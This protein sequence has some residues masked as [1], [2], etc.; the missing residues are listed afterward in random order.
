MCNLMLIIILMLGLMVV[1]VLVGGTL[2]G[3]W[4]PGN[5]KEIGVLGQIEV[6]KEFFFSPMV[7]DWGFQRNHW[8]IG[9]G[10]R[11]YKAKKTNGVVFGGD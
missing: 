6:L 1:R 4:Q 10:R 5:E 9:K 2:R 11:L 8:I 7:G 3:L